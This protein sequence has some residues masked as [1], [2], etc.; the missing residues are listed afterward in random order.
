MGY[1]DLNRGPQ[2][3]KEYDNYQKWLRKTADEKQ[4]AY[5]AVAKPANE[6][7]K[8][9]RMPGYILPF[10]F[11]KPGIYFETNK[12]LRPTQTGRGGALAGIIRKIVGDKR[13]SDTLPD[14]TT[15]SS[16][17]IPKYNFAK[18]ELTQRTSQTPDENHKSR[19][20]GRPYPKYPTDSMSMPFGKAADDA[21]YFDAITKMRKDP[22][23]EPFD[24]APGNSIRFTPEG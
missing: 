23:F 4:A 19:I 6:R 20:T 17:N 3:A 18:I 5:K 11:N 16:I 12:L 14:A 9:E 22:D 2:L 15:N 13:I 7:V 24:K 10:N 21:S 1:T 8:P